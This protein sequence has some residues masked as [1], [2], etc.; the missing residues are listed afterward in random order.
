VLRYGRIFVASILSYLLAHLV[1]EIIDLNAHRGM[2]Q[3]Y[4]ESSFS[5]LTAEQFFINLKMGNCS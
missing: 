1:F 3:Y 5:F 2:A 4:T